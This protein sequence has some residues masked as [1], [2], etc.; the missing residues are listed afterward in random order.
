MPRP[1]RHSSSAE[2]L[3]YSAAPGRTNSKPH[4]DERDA[5]TDDELI[6]HLQNGD[7]AAFDVLFARHKQPFI[8]YLHRLSGN[9]SVAEDVSQHVWMKVIEAISSG[10]YRSDAGA[11][12]RTYLFTLGRN[13]YIDEYTRKFDN[14][15]STTLDAADDVEDEDATPLADYAA[16]EDIVRIR[17]ALGALPFEQREVIAL[18]ADGASIERMVQVTGAGRDTVLSRKKYA[19]AKL[20]RWFSGA[21]TP[22]SESGTGGAV[23]E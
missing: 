10:R 18:W 17:R 2:T 1:D 8:G 4:M 12:F 13:R 15:R 19:L 9:L 20:K 21:Q 6:A 16:A 14:A 23:G 7:G 22:S 11:T 5:Y 3:W